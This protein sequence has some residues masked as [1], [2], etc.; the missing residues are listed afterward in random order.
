VTDFEDLDTR[1]AALEASLDGA[2]GATAAFDAELSQMGRTMAFTGREVDTLSRNVGG[3]LRRAFDGVVFDGMKLSDAL[4][5]VSKSMM[6]AV[7]SASI[8]PVQGAF[9][10]AIAQGLQSAMSAVLPFADGAG[11]SQGRVLPFAD[12]GVVT[13]PV[14]FPMR[15]GRTGLMG[16]AGPEA[17]LPLARGPD[18][19]LG[20]EAGGGG[21]PVNVV[22]NIS[23]PD[24]DGFRRSEGQIAAQVGRLIARGQKNR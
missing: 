19:R 1:V 8:R 5:E 20:V 23:T 21:R 13:G 17:I 24:V 16:E 22:I 14:T 15:G 18:G 3:G 12:G 4:R 9:G 6:D 2:R 7:Y 11:F 10:G